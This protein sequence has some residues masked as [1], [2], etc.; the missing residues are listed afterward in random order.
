MYASSLTPG[1]GVR[2]RALDVFGILILVAAITIGV[3]AETTGSAVSSGA[4]KEMCTAEI[5]T[6]ANSAAWAHCAGRVEGWMTAHYVA[7]LA[8]GGSSRRLYCEPSDWNVRQ[9][10]DVFHTWATE[11]PEMMK[12]KWSNGLLKALQNAFPCSD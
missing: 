8:Y 3:R 6:P 9:I 4:M 12:L 10:A 1:L 7:L 5:D 11:N 2:R